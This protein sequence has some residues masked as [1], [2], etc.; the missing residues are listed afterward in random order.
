MSDIL[1]G[2][3]EGQ[4]YLIGGFGWVA[5]VD[6]RVLLGGSIIVSVVVCV[7]PDKT[8]LQIAFSFMKTS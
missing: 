4:V 3:G 5:D 2:G 1:P 6:G 8:V 7:S